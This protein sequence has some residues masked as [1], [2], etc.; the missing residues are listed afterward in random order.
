VSQVHA[1]VVY[2]EQPVEPTPGDDTQSTL[3]IARVSG[4]VLPCGLIT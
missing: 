3:S 2:A 4:F 1:R